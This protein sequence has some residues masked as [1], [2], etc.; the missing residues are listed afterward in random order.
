M[1]KII[2]DPLTPINV[3]YSETGEFSI[4][5][6]AKWLVKKEA[7]KTFFHDKPIIQIISKFL[8]IEQLPKN[9]TF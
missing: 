9:H 5:Y 2:K 1:P 6:R 3:L 4:K 7:I 8:E